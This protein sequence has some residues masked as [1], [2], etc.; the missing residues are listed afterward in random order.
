MNIYLIELFWSELTLY[1]HN[2]EDSKHLAELLLLWS[3]TFHHFI[4]IHTS[5]AMPEWVRSR[6]GHVQLFVTLWT[7][8]H[9]APLSMGFSRQEYQSGLPCPLPGD[10]PDP[11]IEPG[12]LMSP[13]LA[14]GILP[15]EH[16]GSPSSAIHCCIKTTPALP[17]TVIAST[18]LPTCPELWGNKPLLF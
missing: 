6:F 12:S 1:M 10:L 8:A 9:L 5:P 14:G 15:L 11:G 18:G 3:L 7:I 2:T 4:S 17:Q 13:A 16:L